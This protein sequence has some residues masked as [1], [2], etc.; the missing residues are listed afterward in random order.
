MDSLNL[1]I[2]E[3][4]D[5]E[6]KRQTKSD[7]AW[8][9]CKCGLLNT[10]NKKACE[11][12]EENN[13]TTKDFSSDSESSFEII[14]DD[15][16]SIPKQNSIDC[17]TENKN[18]GTLLCPSCGEPSNGENCCQ[19][20]FQNVNQHKIDGFNWECAWCFVKNNENY[21]KCKDC[22]HLRLD[23]SVPENNKSDEKNCW[24][25]RKWFN[26]V[27]SEA[28][29]SQNDFTL[30]YIENKSDSKA[31]IDSKTID[32]ASTSLKSLEMGLS[33]FN[34]QDSNSIDT[35][36]SIIKVDED[37]KELQE[38]HI[39]I[40]DNLVK[41]TGVKKKVRFDNSK[42]LTNYTMIG[43]D[44]VLIERKTAP[45]ITM[46]MLQ[47]ALKSVNLTSNQEQGAGKYILQFYLFVNR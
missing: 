13:T 46:N 47:D 20:W 5:A 7:N 39:P 24:D 38:H 6:L 34:L 33:K 36:D 22:G 31:K 45:A 30:N 2:Q 41:S 35:T 19:N 23:V 14:N 11:C 4:I 9:C 15:I 21:T 29:E 28:V 32:N 26:K 12:G 27:P 10:Q 25:S 37:K 40:S 18:S 43:N 1:D 42:F 17:K 8:L 3:I 16:D 44:L